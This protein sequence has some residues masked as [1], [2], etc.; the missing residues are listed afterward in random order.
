MPPEGPAAIR[1]PL[2]RLKFG[3]TKLLQQAMGKVSQLPEKEQDA[4]ARMVLEEIESDRRWDDL[5]AQSAKKLGEIADR[6]WACA[7]PRE[8]SPR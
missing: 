5:F 7:E 3:M 1:T 6:E 4:I 2:S 8:R